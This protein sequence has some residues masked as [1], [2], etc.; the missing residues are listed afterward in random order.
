MKEAIPKG[1][2]NELL[3]IQKDLLNELTI[4]ADK[5][6]TKR[7]AV[8]GGFLRDSIIN[9]I[10]AQPPSKIEDIDIVIEGSE[11]NLAEKIRE[12]IDHRE[13]LISRINHSYMTIELHVDN[14]RID[15]ARARLESYPSPAENPKVVNSSIE[16]DLCRRDFT[17]NSIALDIRTN[18][19]IDPYRGMDAIKNRNLEFIKESSVEEDPTRIIRAARYATRLNFKLSSKCIHQIQTTLLLWPWEWSPNNA[20][21]LAPPALATRLGMELE[22]LF[23]KEK[24]APCI[25]VLKKWGALVL[26][27]DDIQNNPLLIR[28]ICWG[29]RL[30]LNPITVLIARASNP[31]SLAVRLQLPEKEKSLLKERHSIINAYSSIDFLQKVQNWGALEWSEEIESSHWQPEA[32]ALTICTG[33]PVW[34]ELLRWW[35]RWRLIRS[36]QTAKDLIKN[37]WKEGPELGQELKRLRNIEIKKSEYK[38]I[39]N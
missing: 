18:E 26:L 6:C 28:Q 27:D 31:I 10:H 15:I 11:L 5:A 23:K 20:P 3:N 35:G 1:F 13:V 17:I 24:W 8:V 9:L 36:N 25:Q 2:M 7:I 34:K 38:N 37:G 14:L 21:E 29:L 33:S 22:L 32:I 30:G 39:S 16:E 12:C 4:A 19:L